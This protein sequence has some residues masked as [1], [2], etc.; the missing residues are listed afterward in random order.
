MRRRR[1]ERNERRRE[2]KGEREKGRGRKEEERKGDE[3]GKREGRGRGVG[4]G[5]RV[6]NQGSVV[7]L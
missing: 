6:K 2:D 7:K 4:G 5:G 1:G 3:G